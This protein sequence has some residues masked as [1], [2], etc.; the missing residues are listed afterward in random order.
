MRRC[1]DGGISLGACIE[2]AGGLR[3][4]SRVSERLALAEQAVWELLHARAVALEGDGAGPQAGAT[5]WQR[6]LLDWDAWT[7][8][9]AVRVVA[10]AGG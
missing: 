6:A 3:F 2:I 8:T 1:R 10:P 5:E 9:H 7:G 4:G